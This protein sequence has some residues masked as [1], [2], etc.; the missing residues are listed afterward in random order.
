MKMK[1]VIII[2]KDLKM[3]R[4][5]EIAQGCHAAIDAYLQTSKE[6]IEKWNLGGHRKICVGVNSLKDLEECYESAK[7]KNI[8]CS[9]I[10]DNGLTEFG[11][12]KTPTAV[13]IGPA[14]DEIVDQISGKLQLL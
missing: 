12:E 7:N 11:G 6:D 14:Q 10:V 1:Q 3:R 13:A 2:R 5:K 4:G 8:P 9:F